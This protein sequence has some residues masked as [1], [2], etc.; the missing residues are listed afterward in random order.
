MITNPGTPA[1]E[2]KSQSDTDSHTNDDA[3]VTDKDTSESTESSAGTTRQDTT[4]RTA[5][6]PSPRK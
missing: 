6:P 4:P 1:Q 2:P 5:T 3:S